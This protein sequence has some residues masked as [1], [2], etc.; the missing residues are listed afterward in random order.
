[1]KYNS[2]YF[3]TKNLYIITSCFRSREDFSRNPS[4]LQGSYTREAGWA[5]A[6][7][8]GSASLVLVLWY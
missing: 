4:S 3:K 1:M 7:I 8:Q 5:V 6:G 2:F